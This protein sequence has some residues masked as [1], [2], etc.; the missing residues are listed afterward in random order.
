MAESVVESSEEQ[1]FES[2]HDQT[3]ETSQE[4]PCE[5]SHPRPVILFEPR[6][7]H[8]TGGLSI[9]DQA[10]YIAQ[11]ALFSGAFSPG[12]FFP[13]VRTLAQG[14]HIHRNTA[15]AVI[16]H[17]NRIGWLKTY[18]RIGTKVAKLPK[19]RSGDLGNGEVKQ[20]VVEA[21]T[22]G[23]ALAEL[24]HMVK[25]QWARVSKRKCG[26]AFAASSNQPCMDAIWELSSSA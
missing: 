1:R 4:E 2:D 15:H 20:L 26:K 19:S 21:Q 11:T 8:H 10:V 13:S 23:M 24:V 12:Q 5:S 9:F 7:R 18:R 14:L 17:L 22:Q 6:V 25:A 16:K 3:F